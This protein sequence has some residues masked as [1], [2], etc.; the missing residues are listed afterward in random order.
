MGDIPPSNTGENII[1][2]RSQR[3]MVK[4][5][6]V[7]LSQDAGN[8]MISEETRTVTV[9]A[10]GAMILLTAKVSVGQLVTLRNAKSGEEVL[11][12]VAYVNPHLAEKKE[13][14]IDFMKPCP[15]FWRISF[16]PPEWTNRAPEAK[17]NT[18]RYSGTPTGT[19]KAK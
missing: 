18:S 19:N 13:V 5:S 12:R 2:R 8:K 10:H 16:P 9:N 15:R 11:C 1:Q 17:G 4:V 14:G 3:V 6:V 7:V